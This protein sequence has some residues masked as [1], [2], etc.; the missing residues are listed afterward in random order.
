M[1]GAAATLSR[2]G[3]ATACRR[4]LV[5]G[6]VHG[7]QVARRRGIRLEFLSQSEHVIVHGSRRRVVLISP[8]FI[9]QLFARDNSLRIG[10]QILEQF[11]LLRVMLTCF[12]ARLASMLVK[13]M[14]ASPKLSTS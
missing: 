4:K 9:E 6:S 3:L 10:C 11:E 5:P 1:G 12:P 14:R 8:H 13:S 2:R 7:Q